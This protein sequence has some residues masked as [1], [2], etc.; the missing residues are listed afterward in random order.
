MKRAILT[1]L[2]L[3]F[4]LI[5]VGCTSSAPK[6][7]VDVYKALPDIEVSK[8][9]HLHI[10]KQL[11]SKE[12]FINEESINNVDDEM[13]IE[14]GKAFVNLFN[15][16]VAEQMK[17]SFEKYISNKNLLRFTDEILELTQK[18]VLKGGSHVSYGFENDFLHTKLE[19]KEDDLYY[20]EL[21]FEFEGSGM[22]CKM[23]IIAENKSLKLVDFYFGYKDGVDTFATGHHTVRKI[24]N[25]N[26]WDDEEWV[27]G[28]F[29]K[30]KE[31]E[32]TLGS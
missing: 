9:T 22:G 19:H 31:L 16:A 17:V 25:P 1:T 20:L 6:E 27:K 18:Q 13:I 5:L 28:V 14:F 12:F 10:L 32:E 29:Y 3:T 11:E 21:Q 7:D 8:D 15:G 23:L 24:N 4:I 26:I 2:L 30:L